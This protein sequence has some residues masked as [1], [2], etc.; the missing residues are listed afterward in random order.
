M[1]VLYSVLFLWSS[2]SR[3][4]I[5]KY[6]IWNNWFKMLLLMYWLTDVLWS[7]IFGTIGQPVGPKETQDEKDDLQKLGR[8][9]L[10]HPIDWFL[11]ACGTFVYSLLGSPIH[12]RAFQF[13]SSG[14]APQHNPQTRFQTHVFWCWG[15]YYW[16]CC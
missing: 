16:F 9:V 8:W 6:S 14:L 5:T 12:H 1:A 15:Q 10:K 11:G 3:P 7:S 4:T 2:Q 13:C